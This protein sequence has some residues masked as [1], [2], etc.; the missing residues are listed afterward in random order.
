MSLRNG[1]K[2]RFIVQLSIDPA[3]HARP[4]VPCDSVRRVMGFDMKDAA[5]AAFAQSPDCSVAD[6]YSDTHAA[7]FLGTVRVEEVEA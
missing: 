6:V 2:R 4:E 5:R 3:A 7:P 1:I